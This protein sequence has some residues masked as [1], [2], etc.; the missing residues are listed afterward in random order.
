MK[1]H[2][3]RDLAVANQK[4]EQDLARKAA[5]VAK[6]APAA[7]AAT[8]ATA[9]TAVAAFS[10]SQLDG[11]ADE[12]AEDNAKGSESEASLDSSTQHQPAPP[13]PKEERQQKNTRK[14]M[15]QVLR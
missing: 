1:Q 11:S 5:H 14:N 3:A 9:A 15:R 12:A 10:P 8:A 2:L 4:L 6:A 7:P 13:L